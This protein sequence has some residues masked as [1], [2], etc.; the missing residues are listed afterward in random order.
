MWTGCELVR[1][2]V[3]EMVREIVR[4][5]VHELFGELQKRAVGTTVLGFGDLGCTAPGGLREFGG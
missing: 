3:R 1:E 4:E 5:L 2:L